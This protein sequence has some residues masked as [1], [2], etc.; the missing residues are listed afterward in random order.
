M[1]ELMEKAR[2]KGVP[3]HTADTVVRYIVQGCPTG[4]FCRAVLSND[5]KESFAY[6]DHINT[7]AMFNIV[8][9]LYNDAPCDC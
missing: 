2:R 9:F 5:L 7:A 8:S 1:N 3:E 6:A 4:S